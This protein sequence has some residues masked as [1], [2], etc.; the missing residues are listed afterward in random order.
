[1]EVDLRQSVSAPYVRSSVAPLSGRRVRWSLSAAALSLV[2]GPLVNAQQTWSQAAAGSPIRPPYREGHAMAY[3]AARG[4]VVLFGGVQTN[5]GGSQL[6]VLGDTWEWDGSMWIQRLPASN[7]AP[8]F[9]HAMAYDSV[10]GK[11]VMF[12]GNAPS[13]GNE[14]WEWDGTDWRTRPSAHRPPAQAGHAMVFDAARGKVVVMGDPSDTWLWDGTDWTSIR[15]H[16]TFPSRFF[17]AMA[18]DAARQRVVLF[19]GLTTGWNSDTWE[20]DGATWTQR[21]PTTV[22]VARIDHGMAFDSDRGVI[23]MFGGRFGGNYGACLNDTWLWDGTNWN[24]DSPNTSPSPR[25]NFAMVHQSARGRPFVFGGRD[26]Y[27][28]YD[29]SW[30]YI[31]PYPA[32]LTPFGAGCAGSAGVPMLAP[33]GSNLPWIGG[34]FDLRL[35]NIGTHPFLNVPFV[36]VGFS[37][38][39]WGSQALPLDLTPF[40]MTGCTLLAEPALSFTLPNQGGFALWNPTL[41]NDPR[42]A[43]SSLFVQGGATAFG[44]NPLGMVL[45]NGC[46]V[47]I[48]AR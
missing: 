2:L 48:G 42:I 19:G 23:V 8:R 31:R 36:L 9:D 4:R 3:D 25:T 7:P 27:Q 5:S 11:V 20:W 45:S 16:S 33:A 10:R 21:S 28:N 6:A 39:L 18:Y 38:T 47:A 29:E 22:P 41:P 15:S 14:T 1:M 40:G 46:D 26:Q 30:E 24:Q 35:D 34:T 12:G 37:R 43:G 17:H 13:P 44:A 32:S